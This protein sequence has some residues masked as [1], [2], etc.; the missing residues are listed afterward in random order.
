MNFTLIMLESKH[1]TTLRW[2]LRSQPHSLYMN[3]QGSADVLQGD[4][5]AINAYPAEA[6]LQLLKLALNECLQARHESLK[7]PQISLQAIQKSPPLLRSSAKTMWMLECSYCL[8][9]GRTVVWHVSQTSSTPA[10]ELLAPA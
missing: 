10:I 8:L 2:R 5:A 9:V 6:L 4:V 7:V 1:M 3:C